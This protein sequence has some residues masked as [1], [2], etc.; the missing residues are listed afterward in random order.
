MKV[1]IFEEDGLVRQAFTLSAP[2][3]GQ[4]G[5]FLYRMSSNFYHFPIPVSEW[6]VFHETFTGPFDKDNDVQYAPWAP[7]EA[8][9]AQLRAWSQTFLAA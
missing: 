4:D 5:A 7:A 9:P 3:A 2:G 1:V 8:D 6:V